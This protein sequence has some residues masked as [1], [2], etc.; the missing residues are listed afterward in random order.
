MAY[1]LK[2]GIIMLNYRHK[3]N[4]ILKEFKQKPYQNNHQ[5]IA[6][7]YDLKQ[8]LENQTH[9]NNFDNDMV[10]FSIYNTLEL[11]A[12][13]YEIYQKH[14]TAD[15]PKAKAQ[16][17]K[18]AEKAETHGNHF[19]L[20]DIRQIKS[21]IKKHK[22]K[23]T[24]SLN[25]FVLYLQQSDNEKYWFE[26]NKNI[27][28]FWR[29][30]K[31]NSEK[32]EVVIHKNCLEKYLPK[33][34]ELVNHFAYLEPNILMD[35]YNN[36]PQNENFHTIELTQIQADENWFNSLE[37]YSCQISTYGDDDN[38]SFSVN[39]SMGDIYD[40]DHILN[41]EFNDKD[42]FIIYYG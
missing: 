9:Q 42:L 15:T 10:L 16:L 24:L 41:L 14:H 36:P 6:K 7:L 3:F 11:F 35:Y 33:I 38:P 31:S 26:I 29:N 40:I 13:A 39:I 2:M 21:N 20:K 28:I 23:I 27:P 4:E 18:I 37:I 19:A 17:Y 12:S 30:F 34:T 1:F 8:E 5:A 32:I 22:T 25:D